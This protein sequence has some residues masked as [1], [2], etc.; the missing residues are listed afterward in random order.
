MVSK[1][2]DFGFSEKIL[3]WYTTHG[4]KHLP[5]QQQKT[6]YSVWVSEIMLQ[7]TQVA[8]V[9]PY[10]ER[11]MAKFPTVCDL[12][13]AAQDDVL[14]LWTGLGYYARARNLHKAA[15]KVRDEHSGKFPSS[16]D[17]VLALPGIGRSTAAA[18]LSL[19]DNQA[20]VIM[21]GNV[22]RVL[23]R[24]FAIEGWPG[25]AKIEAQL[26]TLAESLKPRARFDDYTQAMMDMGA[27]L[28]TR[29]KPSCD[30]C[31]VTSHCLA[32]AQ[33][34]QSELPHK[35]PKKALPVKAVRMLILFCKGS[36][37]LQKRPST[38]IW[39]GLWGFI[40][41]SH[42][43]S[44]QRI[45]HLSGQASATIHELEGF[46][47][48]FSHFHLDISPILIEMNEPRLEINESE[49]AWFSI[50]EESQIGLATPTVKIFKQL[51]ARY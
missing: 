22:K 1:N 29:S 14:H 37:F 32:N 33:G 38:G 40:E 39:G 8:T 28:C 5:W 16:F 41:T 9:I 17:A 46:R 10:F 42:E 30:S 19:A 25:Q 3:T 43:D 18:I 13:N 4:R 7:Q 12:A 49:H 27:T 31:P 45:R 51:K 2:N 11:F 23:S 15:Q 44:K 35:K 21:D 48:T 24:Y 50:H 34:R 36:V 26:W 47:H 20:Y 6:R